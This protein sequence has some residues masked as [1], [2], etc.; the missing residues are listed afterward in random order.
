M[1]LVGIVFR[2]YTSH[3]TNMGAEYTERFWLLV[4]ETKPV[5]PVLRSRDTP[6]DGSRAT[7]DTY[8]QF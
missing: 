7:L 6:L 4:P 2:D 1:Q 3:I 8:V 5:P